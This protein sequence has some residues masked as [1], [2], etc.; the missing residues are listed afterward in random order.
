[1]TVEHIG[2]RRIALYITDDELDS[3]IPADGQFNLKTAQQLAEKAF[4]RWGEDVSGSLEL[5]A[6]AGLGGV[7]LFARLIDDEVFAYTYESFE[8]VIQAARLLDGAVPWAE[9]FYYMDRYIILSNMELSDSFSEYAEINTLEGMSAAV[10][11]EHGKLIC[12]DVYSKLS[13]FIE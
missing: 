6:F 2:N 9:L 4:S 8:E 3:I 13:P 10:I 11:R 7:L 5:E 12:D 1:M